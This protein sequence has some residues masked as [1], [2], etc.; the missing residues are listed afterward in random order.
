MLLLLE[1]VLVEA[2]VAAVVA[3]PRKTKCTVGQ[4]GHTKSRFELSFSKFSQA[5][6]LSVLSA[7]F[8]AEFSG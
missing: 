3:M 6:A 8:E 7:I 4:M 2:A 5:T 1:E